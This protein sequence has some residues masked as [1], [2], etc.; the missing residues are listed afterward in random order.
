MQAVSQQQ[1]Q[2][3]DMHLPQGFVSVE[4]IAPIITRI[5]ESSACK[6]TTALS[7]LPHNEYD[8]RKFKTQDPC[9]T[10]FFQT[11]GLAAK[12]KDHTPATG[13]RVGV[14]R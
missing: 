6:R 12:G 8:V 5:T 2:K 4:M 11:H 14:C 1:K 9:K 7:I 3:R 13:L 10:D